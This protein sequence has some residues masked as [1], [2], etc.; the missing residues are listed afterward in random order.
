MGP[1]PAGA[2]ATR[3]VVSC[4]GRSPIATAG[5]AEN[6][7]AQ[8]SERLR[9]STWAN[10]WSSPGKNYYRAGNPVPVSADSLRVVAARRSISVM[11]PHPRYWGFGSGRSTPILRGPEKCTSWSA[12]KHHGWRSATI[13]LKNPGAFPSENTTSDPRSRSSAEARKDQRSRIM[14][15]IPIQARRPRDRFDGFAVEIFLDDHGDYVAHFS[16]LPNVSA[17]ARTPAK[18]LAELAVAWELVKEVRG[19][20][21]FECDHLEY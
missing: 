15:K 13:F 4:S 7:P 1:A 19:S 9:G 5:G 11:T 10:S 21:L 8:V 17:F 12:R 14:R 6:T 2:Y 18:A 20:E 3:F 16:E